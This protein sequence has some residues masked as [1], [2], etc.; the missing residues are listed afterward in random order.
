MPG[1]ISGTV[2]ENTDPALGPVTVLLKTGEHDKLACV[3]TASDNPTCNGATESAAV[4]S[5]TIPA[6][7]PRTNADGTGTYYLHFYDDRGR[8]VNELDETN[9]DWSD[10]PITVDARALGSL[11][12]R[13]PAPD[14]VQQDRRRLL[15]WRFAIGTVCLLT[16]CLRRP[17]V[18]FYGGCPA[19][20]GADSTRSGAVMATTEPSAQ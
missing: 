16:A 17:R 3:P 6:S 9:N 5:V 10:G 19:P 18:K 14:D 11:A 12:C 20:V 13:R 2:K 15:A 1:Q 7:I 8:V 4:G